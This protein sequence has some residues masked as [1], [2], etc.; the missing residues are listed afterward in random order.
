MDAQKMKEGYNKLLNEIKNEFKS[1]LVFGNF[2]IPEEGSCRRSEICIEKQ[3]YDSYYFKQLFKAGIK[4]Y[5]LEELD[6]KAVAIK[7]Q[8]VK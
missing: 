6:I 3:V 7:R 4:K 5:G 2:A 8:V 1:N